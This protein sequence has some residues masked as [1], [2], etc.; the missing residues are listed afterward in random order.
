MK[1]TILIIIITACL[2]GC[3]LAQTTG[4]E[5]VDNI[6]AANKAITKAVKHINDLGLVV[7]GQIQYR[8]VDAAALDR[9][10]GDSPYK[11]VETGLYSNAGA[12]HNIYILAGLGAD[13]FM[14]TTAH[15]YVHAWQRENCPAAQDDVL[16]EGFARWCEIKALAADGAYMEA[17]NLRLS[18]DPVYSYGFKL[19]LKYED[20]NGEKAVIELVKKIHNSSEIK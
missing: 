10:A 5:V 3:A 19:L 8:V 13:R 6:D 11:G 20:K 18:A 7:R 4:Q 14:A 1:K 2:A 17:Q 12:G 9:L 15:E 16:R